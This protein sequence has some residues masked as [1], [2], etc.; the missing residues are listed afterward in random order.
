MKK[1]VTLKSYAIS[2]YLIFLLT[3]NAVKAQNYFAGSNAGAGN[4]TSPNTAVG[5][6][7][8]RSG[9]SGVWNT[10][11][12]CSTLFSN[13]TG[14][15]NVSIG[16]Q[17]LY[18]NDNGG[19]NTAI[20]TQAMFNNISGSFNT[21]LGAYS[22]TQN[23][24]GESNVAIGVYAASQNVSGSLNV[25]IG[26]YSLQ[27]SNNGILNT[28]LGAYSM[29]QT[30]TGDYNTSVGTYSLNLNT[31]GN[32]NTAVGNNAMYS[33]TTGSY[34]VA[35]GALAGNSYSSYTRCTFLG[36]GTDA[37]LS[38]LSNATAIGNGAL[39]DSSNKVRIGN[40][41][42]TSI[43]GQVGWTTF[44]DRKLKTNIIKSTLG[45]DFIKDLNPV[46]YN[47]TAEGQKDILYTGLIA[48]EVDEA[49]KKAGVAFSAVDKNGEY[50]GIRYGELTVP[51]IKAVQ[52][53]EEKHTAEKEKLNDRI[54]KLEAA[55]EILL[56]Q[57]KSGNAISEKSFL[58]Q[59]QPNPFTVS[60]TIH[61]V[62][63]QKNA[64]LVVRDLNGK[65]LRQV[66]LSPGKGSV[67][68]S[69]GELAAGT[70]TYS[71]IANSEC[72]DTKLMVIAK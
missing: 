12:G 61:Y 31:S 54:K 47:Y 62:L 48:Q 58:F 8:L 35:I 36:N 69:A 14:N 9:N 23:N 68:F 55:I 10:A 34:N 65:T 22:L 51:L 29:Q 53:M 60:T 43:G 67:T 27:Y 72:I 57:Q 4:T 19:I 17:A 52:E 50:W 46:T 21:S 13:K 28:A 59:N 2:A 44:S 37:T 5:G 24:S 49:A 56:R 38:G 41:S 42:V 6:N 30:N 15:Q 40:T 45:L 32:S 64:T 26:N 71:L 3:A 33:S 1:N 7:S 18:F 70:Y 20:G 25:A 39:V 16:H 63:S 66:N 11:L